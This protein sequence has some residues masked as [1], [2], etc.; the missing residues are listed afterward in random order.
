MPPGVDQ[1]GRCVRHPPPLDA[2]LA[3]VDY[4][5]PWADMLAQFKFQNDP[6]WATTLV[7][8][9]RAAPGVMAA[10]AQADWLLPIPLSNERLRERGFNQSLLLAR[11]LDRQRT[12]ADWLLRLRA[13][14]AQ[15][16]LTRAQRL[17]NLRG[18]FALEPLAAAQVAGRRVV[19]VDDVM[20]TGATLQMA[21]TVLRQ[22]GAAHITGLVLARTA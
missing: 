22:A 20:T 2:C 13:T 12:R 18:A 9:V 4:G 14:E 17:R 15:S 5:Y 11:H 6:G 8:H 21:A 1:C 19:L 10:V 16:S 7:A 3:A